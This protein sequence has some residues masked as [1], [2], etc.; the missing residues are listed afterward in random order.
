MKKGSLSIVSLLL[1]VFG[2]ALVGW[3]MFA[4]LVKVPLIGSITCAQPDFG[5]GSGLSCAVLLS[6]AIASALLLAKGRRHWIG[7]FFAGL[8]LG[9]L[10]GTAYVRTQWV[11]DKL[12]MMS[13][14]SGQM[15]S[16]VKS[17]LSKMQPAPGLY[18]L[19][20]GLIFW[21]AGSLVKTRMA[22]R[23]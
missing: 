21:L 1:M 20:A 5:G 23:G 7:W 13:D 17:L 10:G 2:L 8:S 3:S 12:E 6:L 4:P 14:S 19:V 18:A 22:S 16:G 11:M 9:T 15:D